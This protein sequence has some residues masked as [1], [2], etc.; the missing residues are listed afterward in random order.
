MSNK[1]WARI[2]PGSGRF[3]GERSDSPELM[4]NGDVAPGWVDV[5]HMTDDEEFYAE[6][7][8]GTHDQCHSPDRA[9]WSCPHCRKAG[10]V[11]D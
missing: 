2:F 4:S 8:S 5:S 11:S 10:W 6:V 1:K 9:D 3:T 7:E